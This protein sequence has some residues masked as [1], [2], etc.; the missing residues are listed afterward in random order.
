MLFATNLLALAEI[1]SVF[2]FMQQFP[3]DRSSDFAGTGTVG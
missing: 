3:A 2:Q 1:A